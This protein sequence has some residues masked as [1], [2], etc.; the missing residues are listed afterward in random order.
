VKKAVGDPSQFVTPNSR[1]A[2]ALF[3][4]ATALSFVTRFYA[5]SFP[6][7]V[8]YVPSEFCI[9]LTPFPPRL[10]TGFDLA[11]KTDLMRSILVNLHRI[12][13][14]AHFISMFILPWVAC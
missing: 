5:I 14:E 12:T 3:W 6:H 13:Y 10:L 2:Q 1:T 8:V 11:W 9:A 4:F 7:E